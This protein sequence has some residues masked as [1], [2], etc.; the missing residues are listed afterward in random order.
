MFKIKLIAAGRMKGHVLAPAWADYEKRLG[1]KIAVTEYDPANLPEPHP[2][3]YVLALDEKGEDIG[4]EAFA[5]KLQGLQN[6]GVSEMTIYIGGPDGLPESLKNRADLTL[7][8]GRMTW[9]HMMVRVML[10][11]QLYR[12]RQIL[13]GHPYH[14]A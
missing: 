2:Q 1:W 7:R 3:D 5:E 6:R 12:A 4:S 11:E 10:I 8:F 14:R 13:A 9:P